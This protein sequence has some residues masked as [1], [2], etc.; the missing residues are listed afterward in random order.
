MAT[1]KKIKGKTP[2]G[3]ESSEIF[4]LNKDHEPVEETEATEFIILEY[5]KNGEVIAT[6]QGVM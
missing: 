1:H 5:D 2:N 3:G 6:T 4:Y